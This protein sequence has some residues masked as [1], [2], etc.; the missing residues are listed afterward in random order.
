V[1]E[2]MS[3]TDWI[4]YI[5]RWRSFGEVAAVQWVLGKYGQK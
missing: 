4:H 3:D 1:A 2:G 5:D